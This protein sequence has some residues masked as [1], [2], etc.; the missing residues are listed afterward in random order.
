M[1]CQ[2]AG[3]FLGPPLSGWVFLLLLQ[4]L[5][6]F[7]CKTAKGSAP[8]PLLEPSMAAIFPSQ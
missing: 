3:R 8:L 1:K 6:P 2:T 5:R 7:S 4:A